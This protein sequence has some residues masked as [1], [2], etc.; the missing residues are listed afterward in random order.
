MA[1]AD[2]ASLIGCSRAWWKLLDHGTQLGALAEWPDGTR[3]AMR[4]PTTGRDPHPR[5]SQWTVGFAT[6]L[7]FELLGATLREAHGQFD[8]R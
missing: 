4:V 8:G 2:L 7:D 1:D 3:R 5:V 6:E